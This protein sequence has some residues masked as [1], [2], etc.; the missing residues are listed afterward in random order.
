MMCCNECPFNPIT[1]SA[2]ERCPRPVCSASDKRCNS[3]F[4]ARNLGARCFLDYYV[5][6]HLY[7]SDPLA[8]SLVFH[9]LKSALAGRDR[10]LLLSLFH[11]ATD[12]VRLQLWRWLEAY[13]P[14][15][16]WL[17]NPV[18]CAAGLSPLDSFKGMGSHHESYL[19]AILANPYSGGLYQRVLN[20]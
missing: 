18:F 2:K 4:C 11:A 9:S 6:Q 5:I 15:S 12:R 3:G 7:Q 1:G 13:E 14:R 8:E 19:G 10:A 16:L 20:S 17:L